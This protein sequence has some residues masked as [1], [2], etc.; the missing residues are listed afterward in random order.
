MASPLRGGTATERREPQGR[1]WRLARLEPDALDRQRLTLAPV[2]SA[3]DIAVPN[4]D[5]VPNPR[6][7]TYLVERFGAFRHAV[8]SASHFD[9]VDRAA[10][11]AEG[12]LD[13]CLTAVG[14]EVPRTLGE[15]LGA[16]KTILEN[17]QQLRTK[18]PLTAHA[19]HL[20]HKI[21]ELH[22]R[23]HADQAVEHGRTVRP[24]VGMGLTTD[25]SEMLVEVG[26]ARY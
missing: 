22:A 11:I 3:H 12:V 15:R 9:V 19:Y 23:L 4:F 6:L 5:R 21:R 8:V 10:N 20:A 7:R 24:E 26:L 25:L 17:E 2:R 16:A 13:Y 14:Q 1:A 18:F